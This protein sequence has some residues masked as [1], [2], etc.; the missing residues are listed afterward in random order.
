MTQVNNVLLNDRYEKIFDANLGGGTKRGTQ[1]VIF[2]VNDLND[3]YK[4]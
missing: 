1:S 2:R 3:N 4:K